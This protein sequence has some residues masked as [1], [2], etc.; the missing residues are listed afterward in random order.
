VTFEYTKHKVEDQGRP[1]D[2]FLVELI[3]WANE[4]DQEVFAA[5]TNP[6]DIYAHIKPILGPWRNLLHRKAA[7][8]ETIRVHAGFE[9]SWDWNEGVDTTNKTSMA[10]IEGQE[11]GIL[12]VS[13]DSTWLGDNAMKPYAELHG[14]ATP[15]T[16]IRKMKEDHFLALDYYARLVRVSVQWAGPIKRHEIDPYLY[17]PAMLEFERLLA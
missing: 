11:T 10:H 2:S 1:P 3:D 4:A 7:L 16:F 14:I 8:C 17:E 5:N 12:Q 15:S 9:S 6:K 13:F